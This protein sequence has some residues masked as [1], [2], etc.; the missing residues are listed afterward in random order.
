MTQEIHRQPEVLFEPLPTVLAKN[1]KRTDKDRVLALGGGWNAPGIVAAM[2]TYVEELL[3][4][5]FDVV[6]LF[7]SWPAL[8]NVD[9]NTRMIQFKDI[10]PE[11]LRK[12][13]TQWGTQ[14]GVGRDILWKKEFHNVVK[15]RNMLNLIGA[16][17]VGGDG[18]LSAAQALQYSLDPHMKAIID[19]VM[20]GKTIDNDMAHCDTAIGFMTSVFES[21]KSI[22]HGLNLAH[23]KSTTAVVDLYGRDNGHIALHAAALVT[24]DHPLITLLSEKPITRQHF[25]RRHAELKRKYNGYVCVVVAEWFKFLW[26]KKQ[27]SLELLEMVDEIKNWKVVNLL[28]KRFNNQAKRQSDLNQHGIRENVPQLIRIFN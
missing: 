10:P 17:G 11:E 23:G 28:L 15:L 24:G 5:W 6:G 14:L 1:I 26:E 8:K 4:A 22:H 27:M 9:W 18:T 2:V 19:I 13:L 16:C 25:L 12:Y 21:Q 3:N 20:W 7:G